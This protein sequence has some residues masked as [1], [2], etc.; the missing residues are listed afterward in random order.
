MVTP[1]THDLRRGNGACG[2]LRAVPEE[3]APLCSIRQA[4][5][6]LRSKRVGCLFGRVR[7]DPVA[8]G[9][10]DRR[11]GC[12][13]TG[14][15]A[16]GRARRVRSTRPRSAAR[17]GRGARNLDSA[18]PGS[19]LSGCACRCTRNHGN[20]GRGA[21]GARRGPCRSAGEFDGG[22]R[23]VGSR[24]A[25]AALRRTDVYTFEGCDSASGRRDPVLRR[26]GGA[27]AGRTRHAASH[28]LDLRGHLNAITATADGGAIAIGAGGHAL[29][30]SPRLQAQ[31]EAVQTTRDLLALAIDATGVAWAG[32]AQARLLRRTSGSWVRMSAELGL[33]S[34]V[35]ALWAASRAVRAICDDGALIEGIVSDDDIDR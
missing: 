12:A 27:R 7:L 1:N 23:P 5:E 31:L 15:A 35:V 16:T 25:D 10:D 30:L 32:S 17:A 8:F 13:R 29:L 6:R 34:S 24:Q 11:P 20:A 18:R 21:L 2:S 19:E 22:H 14:V 9:T 26:L 4:K 33:S 28:G 3:C